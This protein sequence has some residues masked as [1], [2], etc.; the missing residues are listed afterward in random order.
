MIW[1][2]LLSAR[3]RDTSLTHEPFAFP[4]LTPV[5]KTLPSNDMGLAWLATVSANA[6]LDYWHRNCD[7]PWRAI[8]E[9]R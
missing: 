1:Q 8:H 4:N 6:A 9:G 2:Q 5:F 7:Y 3:P